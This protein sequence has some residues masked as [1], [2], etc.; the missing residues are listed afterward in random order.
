MPQL[1]KRLAVIVALLA[2][3]A[4]IAVSHPQAHKAV[5][6][7]FN[8][9]DDIFPI[10]RDRCGRCHVEGGSAPM[11]L[12]TYKDAIAWAESMR[13]ELQKGHMPPWYV[14][15]QSPTVR[16]GYPI[17][18]KELDM[19]ITWA[20]GGTPQG[21]LQKKLP[22][23]ASH[24]QWKS[25]PPDLKIEMESA[26]TLAANQAEETIDL[27]LPT[28]LPDTKWVKTADLLPG[29]PSMVRNAAISVENGPLLDVWV[30]GNDAMA[31]PNGTAF[32]LPAG[33]KLHLQIHYKKAWQDEGNAVSDR[34][35]I[36]LYFTEPPAMGREIQS[37]SVDAG[38]STTSSESEPRTFSAS[39]TGGARVVALRPSLD[40]EYSTLDVHAVTPT[41]TRVELLLLR[42][43]RPEWRRRYWLQDPI[44]LPSGSK[45]EVTAMPDSPDPG[46][47][48]VAQRYPLQVALDFVSQ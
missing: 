24:P 35:T 22:V 9:N 26:H 11:T 31:A 29:T 47:R 13:E 1:A 38:G 15:P 39:L 40:Q 46:D 10:V 8:Y 36:G 6:S 25:G 14:D 28:A 23:I 44:E 34:S 30:P 42:A 37:F 27:V 16:G 48:R 45:I 19:L 21:D 43:A 5:T 18:A 3:I 20:S 33:A 12:L 32:K 2:V 17:S 41:G 7:R 4:T